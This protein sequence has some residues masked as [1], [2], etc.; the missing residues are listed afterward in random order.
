MTFDF[1]SV[2]FLR[3]TFFSALAVLAGFVFSASALGAAPLLIVTEPGAQVVFKAVGTEEQAPLALGVADADGIL[4]VAEAPSVAGTLTLTHVDAV[5]PAEIEYE[6]G[7]TPGKIS[8][9]LKLRPATLLVSAR[10]EE[11]VE[12]FVNGKHRGRGAVSIGGVVPREKMTVEARSARRGMQSRVV[13]AEPG[14]M[15]TVKFDLRGNEAAERPDGQI[16]L[17][18]LPLVLASQPGATLKADGVP[19]VPEDGVLRGL[20]PGERVVEIFLPWREREVCVWRAAMPARS[21]MLPGAD[22]VAVPHPAP[23]PDASAAAPEKPSEAPAAPAETAATTPPA[24]SVGE[25]LYVIGMRAT[26]SL[27]GNAGLKEGETVSVFFGDAKEPVAVRASGVTPTRA[28]LHLPE[29]AG[30][31]AEGAQCRLADAPSSSPRP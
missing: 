28:I 26:V 12:I 18:E 31:P 2:A 7:K 10:P 4:L 17:P 3:R 30:V 6:P 25:V 16:V 13:S 15:L 1:P 9:A 23:A 19:V 22:V 27:G 24:P 11:E 8:P 20:D 5:A 29:G 21:A 14:E